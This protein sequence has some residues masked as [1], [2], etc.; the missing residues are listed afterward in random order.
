MRHCEPGPPGVLTFGG[1]RG[2]S[3]FIALPSE[4][5]GLS[6][7]ELGLG[8]KSN[9]KNQQTNMGE[10]HKDDVLEQLQGGPIDLSSS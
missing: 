10:G 1:G 5:P 7:L 4:I 2:A 3:L 8:C 6:S 9:N